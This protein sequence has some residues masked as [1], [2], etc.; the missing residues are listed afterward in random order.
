M[1][2]L[3]NTSFVMILMAGQVPAM[4]QT[5]APAHRQHPPAA[6]HA[7]DPRSQH[8]RLCFGQRPARRRE[9]P[10]DADGNFILGPTTIPR[11]R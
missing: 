3:L 7:A 4:A 2:R 9:P 10:P 1:F 5:P 6:S 8:A 11:R